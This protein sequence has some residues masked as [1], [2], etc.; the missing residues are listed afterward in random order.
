MLLP[1]SVCSRISN[2]HQISITESRW[3]HGNTTQGIF[4][5]SRS[6]G[7]GYEDGIWVRIYQGVWNILNDRLFTIW[8]PS[9]ILSLWTS[10]P[11]SITSR[12]YIMAVSRDAHVKEKIRAGR[13]CTSLKQCNTLLSSKV[14]WKLSRWL[15][16]DSSLRP[17]FQIG[18]VSVDGARIQSV[19]RLAKTQVL[20]VF[21]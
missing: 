7:L 18:Q 9:Q 19:S 15:A 2:Y 17:L 1:L 12:W 11:F 16:V 8:L 20:E 4:S 21:R 14:F 5:K 3:V 13:N 6:W 10:N